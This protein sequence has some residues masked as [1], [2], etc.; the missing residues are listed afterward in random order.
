MIK[1]LLDKLPKKDYDRLMYAHAQQVSQYAVV[2]ETKAFVGVNLRGIS[3]LVITE[4]TGA[5]SCGILK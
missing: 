3:N 2:P 5:W 1:D 4:T